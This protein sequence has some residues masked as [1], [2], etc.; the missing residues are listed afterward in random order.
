MRDGR[1]LSN[2]RSITCKILPCLLSVPFGPVPA[3]SLFP[4]PCSYSSFTMTIAFLTLAL[5]RD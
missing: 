1:R 4:L 5:A 3:S 2:P